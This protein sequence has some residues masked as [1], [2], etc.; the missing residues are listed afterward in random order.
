MGNNCSIK[1]PTWKWKKKVFFHLLDLKIL[2][3]FLWLTS[4]VAR[5]AD[6]QF[7]LSFLRNL[8]EKAVSESCP[9]RPQ[10]RPLVL[11][12]QIIR[13]KVNFSNNR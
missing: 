7:R 5:M 3:S 13:L 8:I 11:G 9:C 4:C 10:G 6:E 1:R 12:K 2:N